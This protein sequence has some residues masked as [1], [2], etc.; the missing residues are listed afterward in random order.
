M[1]FDSG[2]QMWMPICSREN[3][4]GFRGTPMTSSDAVMISRDQF[5]NLARGDDD[6]V[7]HPQALLVPVTTVHGHKVH[8]V[9]QILAIKRGIFAV[10]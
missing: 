4:K 8:V 7:V 10:C 1:G 2:A 9:E 3:G 5:G 6:L